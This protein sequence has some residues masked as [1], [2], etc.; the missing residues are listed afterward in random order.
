MSESSSFAQISERCVRDFLHTIVVVDDRAFQAR[1]QRPVTLTPPGL[2]APDGRS[3]GADELGAEGV[4][5]AAELVRP[6]DASPE[7]ESREEGSADD[8]D[9]DLDAEE[10]IRVF[11]SAGMVCAVLEPKEPGEPGDILPESMP[12]AK[13]ADALILDWRIHDNH[14][15]HAL[16]LIRQVLNADQSHSERL[17]LILIYT[18]EPE[19]KRV[20]DQLYNDLTSGQKP[21]QAVPDTAGFVLSN[22]SLRI[23]V[24]AKA[25]SHLPVQ[26]NSHKVSLR[27]LPARLVSEFSQLTSGLISNVALKSLSVL[28]DQTHTLLAHMGRELD[29]AYLTHRLLLPHPDDAIE[30]ASD[31]VTSEFAALLHSFEVGTVSNAEAVRA[32]VNRRSNYSL[33]INK[34]TGDR[35]ELSSEL[36]AN[37]ITH[38][39]DSQ[40]AELKKKNLTKNKFESFHL[41]STDMFIP[42]GDRAEDV[43]HLFTVATSMVRRYEKDQP[44]PWL[45]L[46]SILKLKKSRSPGEDGQTV[47]PDRYL[48]CIHP[49]CDSVRLRGKVRGFLFVPAIP[50]DTGKFDYVVRD[51][52]GFRKLQINLTTPEI[53]H[54]TPETDP[55]LIR[56]RQDGKEY[57]FSTEAGH[58]IWMGHLKDM[59]A[60]RLVNQFAANLA[61]VGLNEYE[62]ARRINK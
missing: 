12:A 22:S 57:I 33:L 50:R 59:Y 24:L 46:G 31:L 45:R 28:R 40:E 25:S 61:R 5:S 54:F 36:V 48:I 52:S 7:K 37:L 23:A 60:Q 11:A 14:G 26:W 41:L 35:I 30:H 6:E 29:A 3:Q 34:D 55:E 62:W 47:P 38:G 19:L 44:A 49:P 16:S 8:G 2:P 42:K 53:L 56:S 17:R 51:G 9:Y 4:D 20:F 10:L 13:R 58:F 43:D 27:E 18:A 1:K 32:W 39:I 21:I 15:E